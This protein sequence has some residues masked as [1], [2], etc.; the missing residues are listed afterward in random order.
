MRITAIGG[1]TSVALGIIKITT[2]I[3]GESYALIADGIESIT[4]VVSS[5][6]LLL[7]LLYSVKPPDEEHPYGHAKLETLAGLFV[8]FAVVG[9][10]TIITIESIREI[11]TPHLTPKW[12][13]LPVLIITIFVKVLISRV[14]S[15][16]GARHGSGAMKAESW[17]HLSDAITS[18]AAFV[19]ISVA[20]A[21]GGNRWASADDWATLV[22]CVVI[23][24]NGFRLAKNAA[25]DLLDRAP[26]ADLMRRLREIASGVDGV[27]GIEKMRV[28][29]SGMGYMMDIHVEVDPQMTVVDSHEIA[30]AVK[31]TLIASGNRVMDVIVHIEPYYAGERQLQLPLDGDHRE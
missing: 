12:F 5:V 29:Q 26:E 18:G 24:W 13:T 30:R 17:H 11:L 31:R 19:G 2:G 7:G 21:G 9:A 28:R 25:S 27:L 15:H 23:Y 4:D 20:L 14:V 10:A 6:A 3:I 22:A 16:G 1:L 8:A